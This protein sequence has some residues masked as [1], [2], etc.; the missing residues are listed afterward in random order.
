MAGLISIAERLRFGLVAK[1]SWA[2]AGSDR[3]SKRSPGVPNDSMLAGTPGSVLRH[4]L[5]IRIVPVV[6][7]LIAYAQHVRSSGYSN[8]NGP[9]S[10]SEPGTTPKI[11]V[12]TNRYPS[13]GFN[14]LGIVNGM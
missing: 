11:D 13:N 1:A 6:T 14:Y 10:F 5:P 9:P 4:A 12:L 3:Q 2:N 8:K 7:G